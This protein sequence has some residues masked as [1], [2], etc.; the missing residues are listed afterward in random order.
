MTIPTK[1][2]FA[3]PTAPVNTALASTVSERVRV[4]TR[5]TPTPN[6]PAP[7]PREAPAMAHPIKFPGD[8]K[9]PRPAYPHKPF[10]VTPEKAPQIEKSWEATLTELIAAEPRKRADGLSYDDVLALVRKEWPQLREAP[11]RSVANQK[12]Y[13][14]K[15]TDEEIWECLECSYGMGQQ[16]RKA[17]KRLQER[18]LR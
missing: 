8:E 5:Q 3:W 7:A 2:P 14:P 12:F 17:K 16:S 15:I 9:P 10:I 6:P 1:R 13:N 18:L 11:M 4:S